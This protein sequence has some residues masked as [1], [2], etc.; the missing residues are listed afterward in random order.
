M[1]LAISQNALSTAAEKI[2]SARS[3][4]RRYIVKNLH[5]SD[6]VYVGTSDAVSS[7]NG[8][9]LKANESLTLDNHNGEVWAI[10]GSNTPSV[11]I[12]EQFE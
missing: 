4:G 8:Y 3:V 11:G 2:I 7:S 6:V 9:Q 5:A 12:V 10:A 1:G